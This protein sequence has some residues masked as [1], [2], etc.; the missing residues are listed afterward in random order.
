MFGESNLEKEAL[1]Q[2]WHEPIKEKLNTYKI[3]VKKIKNKGRED[4]RIEYEDR[5]VQGVDLADTYSRVGLSEND[6]SVFQEI[7]GKEEPWTVKNVPP[8]PQ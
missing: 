5:E 8:P 2:R 7:K 4:E 3:I 1:I 6:I